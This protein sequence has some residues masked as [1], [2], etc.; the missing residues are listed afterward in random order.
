ME[1]EKKRIIDYPEATEVGVN[2]FLLMS[3]Y[4]EST[5]EY[6]SKKVL[7]SKVGGGGSSALIGINE[8]TSEVGENNQLYF[9]R[10][11]QLGWNYLKFINSTTKTGQDGATEYSD[12]RFKGASGYYSFTGS[13]IIMP[14]YDTSSDGAI[15]NIIDGNSATFTR[16]F[17]G[18]AINPATV[19]IDLATPLNTNNFDTFELW[20]GRY[21]GMCPATFS[22]YGS[23]DGINWI[24][25]LDVTGANT[26]ADPQS[27]SYSAELPE[28]DFDSLITREYIKYNGV[29]LP[30][31]F[32]ENLLARKER[33][34]D[35][36]NGKP[37]YQKTIKVYQLNQTFSL[38]DIG[39]G[40]DVDVDSIRAVTNFHRFYSISGGEIFT[41]Q[42][43]FYGDSNNWWRFYFDLKNKTFVTG[44]TWGY[45]W[46][47][48][49]VT[50]QYMKVES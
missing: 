33:V 21:D 43:F 1:Y 24:Q 39:L 37:L 8:P 15:Q 44:G 12:I 3:Q 2:D 28:S 36:V 25:L 32:N 34:V 19:F 17:S 46:L 47:E 50:I 40:N 26:P 9:L 30:A 49:F 14:N 38:A 45:G 7:T 10:E 18:T 16:H 4:N 29:W 11:E 27:I 31:N 42:A 13:S 5:E 23:V 20:T 6:E 41:G 48:L 22:L 35:I